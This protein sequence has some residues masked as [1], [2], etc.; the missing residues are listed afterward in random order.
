[1]SD[2]ES[3]EEDKDEK[4]LDTKDQEFL[5]NL[6]GNTMKKEAEV[7]DL[8][9]CDDEDMVHPASPTRKVVLQTLLNSPP[10]SPTNNRFVRTY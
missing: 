5:S 3:S 8:L 1:M 9:S 4:L 7:I 2:D 6:L 10:K